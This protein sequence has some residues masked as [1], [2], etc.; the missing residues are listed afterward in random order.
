MKTTGDSIQ[1]ISGAD[2]IRARPNL[3]VGDI[4]DSSLATIL[5]RET[6]C[7]SIDNAQDGSCTGVEIEIN[8][9]GS[10]TVTDN[11]PGWPVMLNEDGKCDAERYMTEI[12]ACSS[13]KHNRL[14]AD[15][16]CTFGMAC[17]NAFSES[18]VLTV[19]RDGFEWTQ[20]YVRGRPTSSFA[21]L[22]PSSHHGTRLYFSLDA[23]LLATRSIDITSFCAWLREHAIGLFVTVIH[24]QTTHT[25]DML[26]PHHYDVPAP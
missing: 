20:S 3:Y 23:S 24:N 26:T 9:D 1:I 16:A 6:L 19:W 22:E 17:V 15:T 5:L 2:A 25:I 12:N 8:G 4:T 13:T 11:G 14:I 10:M 18:C 21:R 7:V